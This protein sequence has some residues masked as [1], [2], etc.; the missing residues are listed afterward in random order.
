MEVCASDFRIC[1]WFSEPG[2]NI[3]V[4]TTF[5]AVARRHA[6]GRSPMSIEPAAAQYSTAALAVRHAHI[7]SCRAT[8][9]SR[10]SERSWSCRRDVIGRSEVDINKASPTPL[11]TRRN[12]DDCRMP[13]HVGKFPC[14][15]RSGSDSRSSENALLSANG[16]PC[17]TP[18]NAYQQSGRPASIDTVV[19]SNRRGR[20]L[21]SY[22]H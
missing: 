18:T 3:Q 22:K 2:G 10:N 20:L 6:W 15:L 16:H 13:R 1:G 9:V 11:T 8:K 4:R 17:K 19:V 14:L 7:P 21:L 5:S 12:G